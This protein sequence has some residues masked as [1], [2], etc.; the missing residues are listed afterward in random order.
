MTQLTFE[1]RTSGTAVKTIDLNDGDTTV[2][3]FVPTVSSKD[4]VT[5][6]ASLFIEEASVAALKTTIQEI[7]SALDFAEKHPTG[8]EGVWVLYS[9]NAT[10]SYQSR[11]V[12]GSL[13]LDT[14]DGYLFSSNRALAKLV[15]K[16]LPYW[17]QEAS[18]AL[19]LSNNSVTDGSLAPITNCQDGSNDL[20]IEIDSDQVTGVLQTP[21]ILEF[22]STTNDGTGDATYTGD[23]LVGV[24]HGDGDSTLPTPGTLVCEGVGQVD[25][26]CSGGQYDDLSWAD[27]AENQLVTWTLASGSFLQKKYRAVARLRDT[28][29]Y[30]DLWLK[31]KLLSGSTEVAETRWM[32][33]GD[34]EELVVIGS[35]TIPPYTLGQALDLGNLT[36]G[37]YEKRASGSGALNL[38]YILLM[39]QDS[40]RRYGAISGLGYNQKLVDDPVSGLLYTDDGTSG[41]TITNKIDEGGPLMLRP[42]VKNYLYFLQANTDGL[43]PIARSANVSIKIHPRRLSI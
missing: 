31:L 24:I 10:T 23:L 7:E 30:T 38:D 13:I 14:R 37:L 27:D 43:A 21:A 8:V 2:L 15:F 40:W 9:P 11:L 35:L 36:L 1:R 4:V 28:V 39:P 42:D 26:A 18:T 22:T 3:T 41:Y 12:G 17:E 34:G 20:Y 32:L 19:E 16:R 25:A 29:A 33:V 5:E 6:S